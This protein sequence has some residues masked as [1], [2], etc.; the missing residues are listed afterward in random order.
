MVY[1]FFE[2]T[3][4]S[5]LVVVGLAY[6]ATFLLWLFVRTEDSPAFT[7]NAIMILPATLLGAIYY[8]F[9][10]KIHR[11]IPQNP[12]QQFGV[13]MLIATYSVVVALSIA[14]PFCTIPD[15]RGNLELLTI[16]VS[17][18]VF[19]AWRLLYDVD[20]PVVEDAAGRRLSTWGAILFYILRLK[21]LS[22]ME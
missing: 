5:H 9:A 2:R 7:S 21:R 20:P 11:P 10:V 22:K 18:Q 15:Q 12:I 6:L 8:P 1:R 3:V 14:W 16:L 4:L 19:F 13:N 17:V